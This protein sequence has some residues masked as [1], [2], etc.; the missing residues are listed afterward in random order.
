MFSALLTH[1]RV[2]LDGEPALLLLGH[3]DDGEGGRDG[4]YGGDR[5]NIVWQS[6]LESLE[7]KG[8]MTTRRE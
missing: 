7:S 5:G 3:D 6:G 4:I 2:G 8:G 1:L